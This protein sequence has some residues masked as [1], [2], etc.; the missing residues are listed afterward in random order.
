MK[1]CDLLVDAGRRRF[2]QGAGGAAAGAAVATV[3][4]TPAKAQAPLARVSYPESRLANLSELAVNEPLSVAYPDADAPGVLIKLGQAVPGGAGP[5]GDVVGFSTVCPHKGYP[6]SYN[7]DDKTLN[8]PG[9]YSRFDCERGGQQTWGQASQ[10][11][12]QY[13]L[14]VDDAGDVYAQGLDELL[15]G[16]VSNVL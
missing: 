15:Y 2:L 1:R 7:A 8:C 16:R 13:A 10:N 3:A 9:H 4:A 5:D 12:A 14:R 6:L 11:L